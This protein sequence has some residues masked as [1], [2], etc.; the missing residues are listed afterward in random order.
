MLAG[1]AVIGLIVLAVLCL[2]WYGRAQPFDQATIVSPPAT[3]LV[4]HLPFVFKNMDRVFDAFRDYAL[5]HVGKNIGFV[6][7]GQRLLFLMDPLLIKYMLKTKFS[8]FHKGPRFKEAYEELLGDGI[9]ASDGEP[10]HQQR[11]RASPLFSQRQIRETMATRFVH[12]AKTL[13]EVI[14]SHAA[15]HTDFD[16]QKLFMSYTLDA[17]CDAAFSFSTGSMRDPHPFCAAFDRA[18]TIATWRMFCHPAMWK[19]LRFF[20]LGIEKEMPG[21]MAVLDKTVGDIIKERLRTQPEKES[22]EGDDEGNSRTGEDVLTLFMNSA[23]PEDRNSKY[24]RDVV[25]N[26][27]IAGRDTTAWAMTAAIFLLCRHPHIQKKAA[28]EAARV[29]GGRVAT[30]EESSEDNMPYIEAVF[31]EALRLYP[32]VP[33]DVKYSVH[34]IE[35]PDG[36][37]VPQ[38][39]VVGYPAYILGRL[40]ATWGPDAQEFRPERWLEPGFKCP[41]D[42]AH[43]VFNVGKRLCLGKRMAGLEA[44][45]VLGSLLKSY[46][47]SLEATSKRDLVPGQM[48]WRMA[49]TLAFQNGMRVCV[50]RRD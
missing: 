44:R 35:L 41:P 14:D 17:F 30:Y 37:K 8:S 49:A 4:G 5:A 10:W 26:F 42:Y 43:L 21:C 45:L 29:V 24:L 19:F 27:L 32:S 2:I 23:N 46:D 20:N 47:F 28:Q 34:D 15:N 3:F 48:K 39:T 38:G 9:F 7:P 40:E 13:L 12:H 18:N 31:Q 22:V 25:L 16:L 6:V 33:Y 1:W 11:K 36:T 50:E